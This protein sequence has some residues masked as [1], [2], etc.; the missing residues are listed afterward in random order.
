LRTVLFVA[1]GVFGLGRVS[2]WARGSASEFVVVVGMTTLSAV[3]AGL[4]S[5]AVA[6]TLLNTR[7][8]L[9]FIDAGRPEEFFLGQFSASASFGVLFG[10]LLGTVVI[11]Q[12]R[13][14]VRGEPRAEAP[15]SFW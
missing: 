2:R 9:P 3:A 7:D 5:A 8:S 12:S 11:M 10:L 14:P 1:F 15:K 4:G 6:V 13:T